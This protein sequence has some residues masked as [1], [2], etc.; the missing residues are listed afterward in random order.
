MKKRTL[1]D[2]PISQWPQAR[3]AATYLGTTEYRAQHRHLRMPVT[4][5]VVQDWQRTDGATVAMCW[6]MPEMH[7]RLS[8]LGVEFP[9]R[10]A[11]VLVNGA[12]WDRNGPELRASTGRVQSDDEDVTWVAVAEALGRVLPFWPFSLR[13]PELIRNWTPGDDPTHYIPMLSINVDETVF[14]RLAALYPA[15]H[16]VHRTLMNCLQAA[17]KSGRIVHDVQLLQD[18]LTDDTVALGADHIQLAVDTVATPEVEQDDVPEPVRRDAW[19]QVLAR[20]DKLAIDC[21][22]NTADMPVN[23]QQDF[24]HAHTIEIQRS[25][26]GNEFLS[27][28]EPATYRAV[29]V[30][31]DPDHD[32]T[33]LLDPLTDTPVAIDP[34]GMIRALAP[35]RL[36]S[37]SPLAEL[38]LDGDMWVRTQDGTLYPAPHNTDSGL[39]WG[40]GGSGP[41]TLA[42]LAEK[43]LDDITAPAAGSDAHI[44]VS[45]GLLA[46]TQ[47]NWP[48]GTAL[49]RAQLET[50]RVR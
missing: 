23:V 39:S 11:Y 34:H 3:D 12:L 27:R 6:P 19:R 35:S 21:V 26:H 25:P 47:H 1:R 13:R 14:P 38:I 37:F 29:F 4:K 46:L 18:R 15:G 5:M 36:P 40:Y 31:L 48:M 24:P 44:E 9:D 50:A 41:S 10:D 28:L 43:L 20:T 22:W 49:T 17:Q 33:L 45:P 30:L 32:S 16:A 42:E 8:S 2:T 7:V